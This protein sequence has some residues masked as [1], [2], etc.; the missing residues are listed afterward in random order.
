MSNLVQTA[1]N[2]VKG[3][4]ATLYSPIPFAGEAITAG[5]DCYVKVSDGLVYKSQSDGTAEEA[6]CHG[7]ALNSAG[8]GQPVVLQNGGS[9]N[10]GATLVA[11]TTYGVSDTAGAICPVADFG[12]GKRCTIIGV[13]TTTA[14]LTISINNT[15][16]LI[17]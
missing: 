5:M 6:G 13:A 2:V 1:G 11:A 14:L 3:S 17:S 9:I 15:G 10:L 4:G 8:I 12:S 7:I 16:I